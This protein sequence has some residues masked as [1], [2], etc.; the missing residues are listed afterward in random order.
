MICR[1]SVNV[2]PSLVTCVSGAVV[3]MM[4]V[5]LA[6]VASALFLWLPQDLYGVS[7]RLKGWAPSADAR[8][9]LHDASVD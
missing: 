2:P 8:I 5:T 7:K 6:G 9:N 4:N 3:S 1:L